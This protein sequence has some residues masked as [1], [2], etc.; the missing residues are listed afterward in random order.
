MQQGFTLFITLPLD[1]RILLISCFIEL[2][3]EK[4]TGENLSKGK[5]VQLFLDHC[6]IT[7]CTCVALLK[8]RKISNRRRKSTTCI[9]IVFK[10]KI[11]TK[12]KHN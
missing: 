11:K 9:N 3:S 4:Y 2:L 8:P 1:A 5:R 12:Q 6:Y 7:I 10:K